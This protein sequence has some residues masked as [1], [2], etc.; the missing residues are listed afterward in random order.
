M[1]RRPP[2]TWK[3]IP[4]AGDLAALVK[5]EAEFAWERN[6]GRVPVAGR[7]AA[8][9]RVGQAVHARTQA[10]MEA[11]HNAP[12]FELPPEPSPL[13]PLPTGPSPA[14]TPD[15]GPT[16]PGLAA[17][18]GDRTSASSGLDYANHD[19]SA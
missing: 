3:P 11:F 12:R 2:A 6:T 17:P 10:E 14:S 1:A 19:D 9:S 16:G 18:E 5:C 8:R 15:P 13:P 4:S 7:R